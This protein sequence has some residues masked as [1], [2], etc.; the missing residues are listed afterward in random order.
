MG[1]IIAADF[2]Q[3]NF[4]YH[5][6][7]C[8]YIFRFFWACYYCCCCRYDDVVWMEFLA[9]QWQC[10]MFYLMPCFYALLAPLWKLS[11]SIFLLFPS[12]NQIYSLH[13]QDSD[14]VVVWY[15]RVESAPYGMLLHTGLVY[16][17]SMFLHPFYGL[18]YLANTLIFSFNLSHGES[19]YTST[20]QIFT[21]FLELDQYGFVDCIVIWI[22]CIIAF[23]FI[24]MTSRTCAFSRAW[25][26]KAHVE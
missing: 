11:P 19:L 4:F 21:R 8:R 24:P 25:R 5:H 10:D 14:G 6:H 26:H 12:Q 1:F 16:M 9:K 7:N 22:G 2:F 13:I 23:L 20:N 3:D 15:W 17:L 18:A